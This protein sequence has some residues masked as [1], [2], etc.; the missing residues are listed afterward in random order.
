VSFVENIV[1]VTFDEPGAAIQALNELQR[2]HESK[3]LKVG[4]AAV[5][6]RRGDGTWRV[7][8]E[9][10]HPTFAGTITGGLLG[11]ILGALTGPLGLLLGGTAGL[12]AGELIDVTEDEAEELILEAMINRIPPGSTALL[13]DVDEPVPDTLDAIMGKLGG[14]IMRWSRADVEAELEAAAE[15][16]DAG[17]R[18]SR[19]IFHLKKEKAGKV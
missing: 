16:T 5:L 7:A 4:T 18:E 10:E 3:A 8:H 12:L 1:A 2:L 15:A 17:R 9:T 19:R 6:E 11:A 14:R 13:A